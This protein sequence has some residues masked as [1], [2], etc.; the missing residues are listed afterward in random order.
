MPMLMVHQLY[1]LPDKSKAGKRKT[2]VRKHTIN[3]YF[4]ETLKYYMSLKSLE[5]RTLWL[6]VWHSDMFGRN[7]FLGEV[8]INLQGKVFDNPQPQWYLLQE[9][10]STLSIWS[11]IAIRYIS[12][13]CVV[14]ILP[15][16]PLHHIYSQ[17]EP[18]DEEKAYR[19]DII[20]GL[21]FVE[22]DKAHSSIGS[23]IRKF[24]SIKT[25]GG[26]GSTNRRGSLHVLVKEAK[27]LS[28]IKQ[29]GTCDAFCKR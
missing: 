20:V 1:L 13:E 3:P 16:Y 12:Y 6:T 23:G 8:R 25:M 17:S 11:S 5:A 22:D 9:R 26:Y 24:S 28:P 10:V 7:D 29:S 14:D 21:K 15:L 2:K 18:F 19:G 4:D 27:H